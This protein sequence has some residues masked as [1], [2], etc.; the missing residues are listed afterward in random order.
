LLDDLR[1]ET[2]L[3]ELARRGGYSRFSVLRWL[4]AGAEPA[5]PEFLTLIEFTS[6]RLLDFVASFTDPA[7]LPSA[8]EAW[9]LLQGAREAA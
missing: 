7:L 4:R 3:S 5:L 2:T 1:G 9:R 8:R 6:R